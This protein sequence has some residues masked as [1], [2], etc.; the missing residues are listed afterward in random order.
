MQDLL[1]PLVLMPIEIATGVFQTTNRVVNAEANFKLDKKVWFSNFLYDFAARY[2][3]FDLNKIREIDSKLSINKSLSVLEKAT[4]LADKYATL[5]IQVILILTS[6]NSPTSIVEETR[7]DVKEMPEL[8][9]N[10]VKS[11]NACKHVKRIKGTEKSV[12]KFKKVETKVVSSEES[13]KD[14]SK[15][16]LCFLLL[17]LNDIARMLGL[18]MSTIN[19]LSELF[20]E[21]DN[22]MDVSIFETGPDKKFE[23][24]FGSNYNKQFLTFFVLFQPE[25][26]LDYDIMQYSSAELPRKV[27][28]DELKNPNSEELFNRAVN[29]LDDSLIEEIFTDPTMGKLNKT[30][31]YTGIKGYTQKTEFEQKLEFDFPKKVITDKKQGGGKPRKLIKELED[32]SKDNP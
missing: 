1:S 7:C 24:R 30:Q 6:F 23:I 29:S 22:F 16:D 12:L 27:I 28:F 21:P 25:Y 8:V 26:V 14:Y 5:S 31:S 9:L 17:E 10:V 13:I 3:T 15:D 18:K 32:Y 2:T 20:E 19:N 11:I 4:L